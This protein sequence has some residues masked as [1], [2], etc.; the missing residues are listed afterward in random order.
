MRNTKFLFFLLFIT[1]ITFSQEKKEFSIGEII[2]LKSEIL[3]EER[4]LNIALPNGYDNTKEEKYPIIYLLDGSANED[5]LHVVGLVQFFNLQFNMPKTIIVGIANVD[6]KR[7]FTYPTTDKEL[8]KAFPTTG[9]SETFINFIEKEL[10]P[11]INSN[12]KVS[13]KKYI[14]GQS[15]GGLLASEIL[16]KKP[17]LFT[18]YIITSPSLWWDNETL[19]LNASKDLSNQKD[20]KLNVYLAVGKEGVVMENDAKDFAR[21]I[22]SVGK[23]NIKFHFEYF[24]NEN[25]ATILHNSIY[26]AFSI[27]FP[28]KNLD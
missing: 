8:I 11:F 18:N 28:Y 5:F 10:Q 19:L 16:L 17:E 12:Y 24:P 21:A 25:H 3:N 1:T 4:V 9:K 15:L 13:D 23:K 26:K 2:T 7:D 22:E 27:E 6:R 14:I 20:I